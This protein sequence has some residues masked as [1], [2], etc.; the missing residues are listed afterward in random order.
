MVLYHIDDKSGIETAALM[1]SKGYLHV[2]MLTG[3][4]EE[5]GCQYAGLLEGADIPEFTRNAYSPL[6]RA[7][8]SASE[9]RHVQG[10]KTARKG[11]QNVANA[12]Q[13]RAQKKGDRRVSNH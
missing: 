7:Q 3:G 12:A 9:T 2:I 4:L 8:N 10:G 11:T 5:F 6:T 1:G 13:G